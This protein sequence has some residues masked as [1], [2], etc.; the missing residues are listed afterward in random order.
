MDL[1][2]SKAAREQH[3]VN[4][5]LL[6][7]S[8]GS[9]TIMP[10]LLCHHAHLKGGIALAWNPLPGLLILMNRDQSDALHLRPFPKKHDLQALPCW[11]CAINTPSLRI[12]C[13]MGA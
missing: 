6:S 10:F 8:L 4:H 2:C 12:R 5:I 7:R 9:I 1:P 13:V 11:N 3:L